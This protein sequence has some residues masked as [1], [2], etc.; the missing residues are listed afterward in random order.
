[1]CLIPFTRQGIKR[2]AWSR[3][4]RFVQQRQ[5]NITPFQQPPYRHDEP[6]DV[7]ILDPDEQS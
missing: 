5:I 6:E 4:E 1:L 7:I 2:L 3:I